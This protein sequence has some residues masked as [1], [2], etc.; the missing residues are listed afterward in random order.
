M[1]YDHQLL[2]VSKTLLWAEIFIQS[3]GVVNDL[4][5]DGF[6]ISVCEERLKIHPSIQPR[7]FRYAKL[8]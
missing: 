3:A 2:G 1:L 8:G 5:I 7:S 6:A 4:D